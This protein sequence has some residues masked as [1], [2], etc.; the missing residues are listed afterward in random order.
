MSKRLQTLR[1][2]GAFL[3]G[4]VLFVSAFTLYVATIS[5]WWGVALGAVV[6]LSGGALLRIDRIQRSSHSENQQ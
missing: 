3:S 6:L 4:V 2:V 5:F 1:L